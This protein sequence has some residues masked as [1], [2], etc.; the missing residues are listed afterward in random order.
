MK[1]FVPSHALLSL[2]PHKAPAQGNEAFDV[3]DNPSQ[4]QHLGEFG[5][6]IS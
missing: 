6:F 1:P 5:V 3:A 4:K 2:S